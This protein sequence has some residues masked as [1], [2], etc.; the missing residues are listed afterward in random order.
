MEALLQQTTTLVPSLQATWAQSLVDT[1]PLA[2]WA[3]QALL[4]DARADAEGHPLAVVNVGR[5]H[6]LDQSNGYEHQDRWLYPHYRAWVDDTG[7]KPLS[8]RRFTGL[9]RDLFENQL[10]LDGVEHRD[11]NKGSRFCGIRLRTDQDADQPCLI[12]HHPPPVTDGTPPVTAESRVSDGCDTCDGFV[13]GLAGDLAALD[14]SGSLLQ[15]QGLP[16]SEVCNNPS[17]TSHPSLV[18]GADVTAPVPPV[19]GTLAEDDPVAGEGVGLVAI[20][21]VSQHRVSSQGHAM[22]RRPDVRGAAQDAETSNGWAVS[23]STRAASPSTVPPPPCAV[24]GSTER[25]EQN[26]VLRCVTCW[27]WEGRRANARADVAMFATE[28]TRGD[29]PCML[30][31]V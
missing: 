17:Y 12:T 19:T 30:D 8:S 20:E 13:Q 5:A 27:P 3:N 23:S 16:I 6:R 10:R 25:W 1:N 9:L 7:G 2:E 15:G 21:R 4:R 22:A 28:S 14:P 11:D 31:D 26:G 29:P 24:C 18:R